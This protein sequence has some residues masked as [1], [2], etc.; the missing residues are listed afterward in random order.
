MI[1]GLES[2]NWVF[3]WCCTYD[4]HSVVCCPEKEGGVV[5]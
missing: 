3:T 4:W 2:N 1:D 5:P